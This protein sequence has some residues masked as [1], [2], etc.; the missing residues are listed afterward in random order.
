MRT[1]HQVSLTDSSPVGDRPP[2]D[3]E[4]NAGFFSL[5]RRP[6]RCEYIL[7]S[8][9]TYSEPHDEDHFRD[10]G[11]CIYPQYGEACLLPFRMR[12]LIEVLCVVYIAGIYSSAFGLCEP[13]CPV[14]ETS[15]R[16]WR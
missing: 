16:V 10:G 4:S 8:P 9:A 6:K 13:T 15:T 5:H 3:S 7:A 2:Q 12:C 1:G 11:I 14:S